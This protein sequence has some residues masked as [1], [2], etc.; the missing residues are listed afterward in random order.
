MVALS[1]VLLLLLAIAC[2]SKDP[3]GSSLQ[4]PWGA[5]NLPIADGVVEE[6]TVDELH[7]VFKDSDVNSVDAAAVK[8]GEALEQHGWEML[9]ARR[10]GPMTEVSL[11][12]GDRQLRMILSSSGKRVD[13]QLEFR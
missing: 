12:K 11:S 3:I 4:A 10:V 2:G 1:R 7:V 6:V 5:L 13:I 9:D 8:F